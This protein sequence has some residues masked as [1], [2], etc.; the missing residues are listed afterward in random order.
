M[1]GGWVDLGCSS[2]SEEFIDR[3]RQSGGWWRWVEGE[4]EVEEVGGKLC[5]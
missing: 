5:V 4:V 1:G 3:E 2:V